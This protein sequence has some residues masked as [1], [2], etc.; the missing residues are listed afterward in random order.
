MLRKAFLVLLI[1]VLLSTLALALAA[2]ET[3]GTP[4]PTVT[5]KPNTPKPTQDSVPNTPSTGESYPTVEATVESYPE[6]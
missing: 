3:A 2:C 1:V 5:P 4:Q 6:P